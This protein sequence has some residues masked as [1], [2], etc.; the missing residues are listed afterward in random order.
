MERF[1]IRGENWGL[2]KRTDGL[3]T[4]CWADDALWYRRQYLM[5]LII[6][7]VVVLVCAVLSAYLVY[8]KHD[9][10]P[11]PTSTMDLE[12]IGRITQERQ[13]LQV[14]LDGAQH[15]IAD[16]KVKATQLEKMV[17]AQNVVLQQREQQL[18]TLAVSVPSQPI[19]LEA[20]RKE[21]VT[22]KGLRQ[23]VARNFGDGIAK[24]IKVIE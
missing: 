21:A 11:V 16:L 24:K 9:P 20:I 22:E 1:D 2:M 3:G 4:M 10:M 15:K 18:K 13:R 19:I 8:H 6:N 5:S 7:L 17:K 14:Q 23:V 12:Q